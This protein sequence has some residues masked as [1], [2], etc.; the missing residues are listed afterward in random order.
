[1]LIDYVRRFVIAFVLALFIG[2][3]FL[4]TKNTFAHTKIDESLIHSFIWPLEGVIT[5]TYGTREGRHYGIDIAAAEGTPIFSI[6]D[7]K[8]H[9]SFYSDSY[10]NVI[11]IEHDNGLETVYAHLQE[12]WVKAGDIVREGDQI[13]T[14][15]NTG[16]STGSHLHFEVHVGQWN[17]EKSNSIDPLLI[18]I[19]RNKDKHNEGYANDLSFITTE[20]KGELVSFYKK[21][22]WEKKEIIVQPG[23]TLWELSQTYDVSI[24][25]IKKW[26]ELPSDTIYIDQRLIIYT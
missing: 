12:R 24:E 11:F 5:D 7:G 18:L 22:P 19:D 2:I 17:I 25:K 16:K 8:V 4:G 23:D 1:M 15:G 13:G 21:W 9:R 14:V 20:K 10:G 3:L 26:N 6:A